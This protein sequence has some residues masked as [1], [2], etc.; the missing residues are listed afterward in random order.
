MKI[1]HIKSRV[2]L[3]EENYWYDINYN[4]EVATCSHCNRRGKIRTKVTKKG[5]YAISSPYCPA[6]GAFMKNGLI[7]V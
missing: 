1:K 2:V 6:C 7:E 4:T 5:D 3:P